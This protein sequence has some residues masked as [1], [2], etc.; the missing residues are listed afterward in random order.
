MTHSLLDQ[1]D[2]RMIA[3][4]IAWGKSPPDPGNLRDLLDEGI[5]LRVDHVALDGGPHATIE[6]IERLEADQM[7]R[8]LIAVEDE[9]EKEVRA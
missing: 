9:S 5:A 4:D 6:D 8:D 3:L 2:T 1:Q 7:S